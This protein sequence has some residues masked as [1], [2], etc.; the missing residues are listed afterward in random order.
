MLGYVRSFDDTSQRSFGA[1]CWRTIAT[2]STLSGS[3]SLSWWI[4]SPTVLSQLW[5]IDRL[6]AT[7]MAHAQAQ[8]DALDHLAIRLFLAACGGGPRLHEDGPHFCTP[9]NC[10]FDVSEHWIQVHTA[11]DTRPTSGTRSLVMILSFGPCQRQRLPDATVCR[12]GVVE[13]R[14]IDRHFVLLQTWSRSVSLGLASPWT[15]RRRDGALV[16]KCRKWPTSK[17]LH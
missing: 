9:E 12:G 4:W 11:C 6:G 17:W 3:W 13:A 15:L 14:G 1:G 16:L 2:W 5:G 10:C 7:L 8:T